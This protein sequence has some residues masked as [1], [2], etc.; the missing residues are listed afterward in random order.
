MYF[1]RLC[2]DEIDLH[3]VAMLSI[4][5]PL[6][7]F[8]L[9]SVWAAITIAA[10]PQGRIYVRAFCD[11]PAFKR[12]SLPYLMANEGL[13]TLATALCVVGSYCLQNGD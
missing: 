10:I 7:L 9:P 11:Y 12:S 4:V 2:L 1:I 8:V 13:T 3:I 5:I 6:A